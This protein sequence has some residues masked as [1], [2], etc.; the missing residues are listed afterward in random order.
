MTPG[1]SPVWNSWKAVSASFTE[2][3]QAAR[4]VPA[5]ERPSQAKVNWRLAA[6]FGV[7]EHHA[8]DGRRV[9][10]GEGAVDHHVGDGQLALRG[11]HR[12]LVVDRLGRRVPLAIGRASPSSSWNVGLLGIGGEHVGCQRRAVGMS[13]ASM[14]SSAWFWR[15]AM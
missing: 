3:F 6:F 15:R 12:A 9:F 7:L 5:S 14:A 4:S 2:R 10:L 11:I 8:A 1:R 13:A